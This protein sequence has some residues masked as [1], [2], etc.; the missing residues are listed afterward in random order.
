MKKFSRIFTLIIALFYLTAASSAAADI[1]TSQTPKAVHPDE[2]EMMCHPPLQGPTG[3]TGPTGPPNGP[4]GPT[5]PTGQTGTTGPAGP[6]GLTGPTGPTGTTGSTGLIG[7]VGNTGATGP[8]G[9]SSGA[10][11]PTGPTGSA[12]ITGPTGSTGAAGVGVTDYIYATA[13]GTGALNEQVV[14][15]NKPVQY[16]PRTPVANIVYSAGIFTIHDAGVY[17]VT[18]G[19]IWYP[20]TNTGMADSGDPA[21]MSLQHNSSAFGAGVLSSVNNFIVTSNFG[22]PNFKIWSSTSVFITL[23]ANDTISVIN[24]GTS[25]MQIYNEQGAGD[26]VGATTAY[27]LIKRIM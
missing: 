23:A 5:G 15:L 26:G 9:L 16:T 24:S 6:T 19:G 25:D 2:I 11:G 20:T 18:F 27:I 7:A 8:A 14:G 21:F 12:G 3:P 1:S 17:Q 13:G 4:T 22:A 10:T